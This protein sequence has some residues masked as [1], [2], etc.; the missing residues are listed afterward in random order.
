[1]LTHTRAAAAPSTVNSN[2]TPDIEQHG[3]GIRNAA[4]LG[5]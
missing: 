2:F 1:V 5:I 4:R 3:G